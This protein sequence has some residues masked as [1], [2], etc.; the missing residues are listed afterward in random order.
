MLF[1]NT[2]SKLYLCVEN[3]KKRKEVDI[4]RSIL[5]GV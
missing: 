2:M 1:S 4:K 3:E 5:I